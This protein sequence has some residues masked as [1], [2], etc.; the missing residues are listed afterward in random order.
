MAPQILEGELRF[1][2]IL[3]IVEIVR[4]SQL[5]EFD[6]KG[7]FKSISPNSKCIRGAGGVARRHGC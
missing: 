1:D 3:P 6:G 4:A 7:D 2:I 5:G